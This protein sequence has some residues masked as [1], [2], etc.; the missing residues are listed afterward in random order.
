MFQDS[1]AYSGMSINDSA[2]AKEFYENILGLKVTEMEVAG[3]PMLTLHLATGGR[4]LLYPKDNHQPATYTVLYLPVGDIDKA[5]DELT[6]K[7]IALERYEGLY[8][9]EKGVT[10]GLANNM[11]PDIAWFKDPAGNVLAVLQEK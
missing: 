3:M 10:R 9:D 7:G 4:V 5:V 1:Q 2:A 8:Q 11:G 6:G